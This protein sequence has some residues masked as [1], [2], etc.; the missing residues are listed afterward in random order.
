MTLHQ[1]QIFLA[2]ADN[3]SFSKGGEQVSLAQ[4]TASQHI[5]Q[6]EDELGARLFDRT[7]S[8]VTLTAAGQLFYEHAHTI[9]AT[10]DEAHL[11]LKRFQGMEVAPLRLAA[12]SIPA[13]YLLPSLLS[14]FRDD[15]PGVKPVLLQGG[16]E[17][18]LRF[19]REDQ[20]ELGI[21]GWQ[22]P[23]PVLS[24]SPVWRDRIVLVTPTTAYDDTTPISLEAL[25]SMPM[26][27]RESG[28]GTGTTVTHA[29]RAVGITEQDLSVCARL[30]SSEAVREAV[31]A[32]LGCAF[33]SWYAVRRD[34][35][36]GR[37]KVLNVQGVSIERSFHLVTRTGRTLSPAADTMIARIMATAQGNA[38]GCD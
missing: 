25:R 2:V 23:D 36:D 12:S 16:S 26:I 13:S 30:G 32:G 15:F 14:H 18:V 21:V 24:F 8:H 28:S 7:T 17:Q 29:L 6:L 38:G 1:L 4:S 35:Q 22:T 5:R 10:V 20:A 9:L 19:V 27:M 37:L 34:C 11:C 31:L 3:Q 33:L